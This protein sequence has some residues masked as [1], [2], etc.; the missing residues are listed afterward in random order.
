MTGADAAV[1]ERPLLKPWFR[2]CS[3]PDGLVLEH[4]RATVRFRGAAATRLLPLLVP[5]LDGGRTVPEIVA[6]VGA[7]VEPATRN[8]LGLLAR[9]GLLADG[10]AVDPAASA[11][12]P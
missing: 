10:P 5:L 6:A 12:R 7:A 1:P 8:A 4:G 2:R 9:H 3:L 11:R